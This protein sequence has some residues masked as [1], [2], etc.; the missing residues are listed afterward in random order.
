M[1][2]EFVS[3]NKNTSNIDIMGGVESVISSQVNEANI[4]HLASKAFGA[5]KVAKAAK[6]IA[7][8]RQAFNAIQAMNR[9]LPDMDLT[10]NILQS[11]GFPNMGTLD[12]N[13]MDM[14]KKTYGGDVLD[15]LPVGQILNETVQ[16]FPYVYQ[17]LLEFEVRQ[18]GINEH[19]T[20]YFKAVIDEE[21]QEQ[22][23]AQT[24]DTTKLVVAK[25][26]EDGSQTMLFQGVVLDAQ[27]R[28]VQGVYYL[29]VEGISHSYSL[30][31]VKK[32]R[33]FQNAAMPYEELIQE[34]TAAYT[35]VDFMDNASKGAPIGNFTMQYQETDWEF[36]KRMASRFQT[37]LVA[38]DF[39]P[40]KRFYFGLPE[41]GTKDELVSPNYRLRKDVSR[42]LMLTQ[43]D[44]LALSEQDFV[45][46]MVT[47]KQIF[48]LADKVT[49]NGR[50]LFVCSTY[51]FLEKGS[52]THHYEL[53][54]EKGMIERQLYNTPIIGASI[55]GTVLSIK[56]DK[57]RVQLNFDDQT[58]ESTAHWFP[59]STTY[60]SKNNVGW[61]MM[62]EIGDTVRAYFPSKKEHEA[63][64]VS[65]VSA[66][67][68]EANQ[69]TL[70]DGIPQGDKSGATSSGSSAFPMSD[71]NIKTLRNKFGKTV[72]LEPKKITISGDTFVLVLDDDEGITIQSE[73]PINVNSKD[74]ILMAAKE[75]LLSAENN[76]TIKCKNNAITMDENVKLTG[77]EVHMN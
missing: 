49:F 52:L 76:I 17:N 45:Y 21:K 42:Y 11:A 3:S 66:M 19:S 5:K 46:Y 50:E 53:A 7:I 70:K 32:N 73:Q 44:G 22:Y 4:Q 14:L 74:S 41:T 20:L 69:P 33:S 16:I 51:R 10:K 65:S 39:A 23:M 28:N 1:P 47:T 18:E 25:R 67:T 9:Q 61:Y 43:N 58:D 31:I 71:P 64:A 77:T 26:E 35:E 75:I 24:L 68:P 36:L 13:M 38:V 15:Q 57:I 48:G 55:D 12:S 54:T 34:V 37:G 60:T 56:Q 8:G 62:P 6:A 2:K 40:S 27:I 59:Y 30:D 29:T 72:T 63:I